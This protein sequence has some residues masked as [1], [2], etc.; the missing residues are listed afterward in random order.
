MVL[1]ALLLLVMWTQTLAAQAQQKPEELAQ[2]SAEAWLSLADSGKY[3]ETWDEAAQ[4]FRN[5]IT[6]D[7][8]VSAMNS[9]RAPLGSVI[10]RK[11]TSAKYTKTVPGAPDG[12]YVILQYATSFENKKDSVET[13]TPMLDK[14]GKWRVAGY[15]I[16]SREDSSR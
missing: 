9:V 4:F 8:W 15:Y 1:S 10:F 14:D 5:A 6:K 11:L 16:K 2:K 3:A 12:E 13:I 7:N